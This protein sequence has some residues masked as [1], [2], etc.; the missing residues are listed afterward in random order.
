MGTPPS[1]SLT[2]GSQRTR[3]ARARTSSPWRRWSPPWAS[4]RTSS[5][6]RKPLLTTCKPT[7]YQ[8]NV[9][10]VQKILCF[11]LIFGITNN[12][13]NHPATRIWTIGNWTLFVGEKNVFVNF[14]RILL[15]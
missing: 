9:Q 4:S 3:L 8:Q 14:E 13:L 6:R 1:Q 2:P 11:V 12:I 10:G 7:E 15:K 5:S